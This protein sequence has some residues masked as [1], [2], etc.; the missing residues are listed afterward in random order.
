MNIPKCAF[1]G[2]TDA[3]RS[4][5]ARLGLDARGGARQDAGLGALEF[6]LDEFPSRA[7]ADALALE[8]RV[9]ALVVVGPNVGG[10][11]YH[12]ALD[13]CLRSALAEPLVDELVVVDRGCAGSVLSALRALQADRRDVRLVA[14]ASELNAAAAANLGAEAA[15][16]RWLLLLDPHLVVQRGAVA[17]L[18]AAA[19][20]AQSPWVIGG[21]VTDA[22]GQALTAARVGE[23][24]AWT[25]VAEAMDWPGQRVHAL[26]EPL[27][28]ASASAALLLTPRADF[29]SLG[30]FDAAFASD[31]ADLD[32]CRRVAS[33]GG[34]VLL[35]PQAGGVQLR[36][37]RVDRRQRARALALFASRSAVTPAQRLFAAVARPVLATLLALTAFVL[38]R[39]P[40]FPR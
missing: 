18:A 29:L 37:A 31:A 7:R 26:S 33:R 14:A 16:G 23:L 40:R 10:A 24:N 8:P 15:C 20:T 17:R 25:A 11:G 28:A 22:Q 39:P 2:G 21:R 3:H 4:F 9:S 1:Q 34:S 32:L 19:E 13:L 6:G 12:G 30:G 38:G 27:P 35:Q 5:S 36:R